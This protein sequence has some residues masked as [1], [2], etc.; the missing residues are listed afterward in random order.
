[1]ATWY[2]MVNVE[3]ISKASV[4]SRAAIA[5]SSRP[6]K[7]FDSFRKDASKNVSISHA[8]VARQYR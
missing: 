5:D 7:R 3:K 4:I 8:I 2:T 1:M 6:N